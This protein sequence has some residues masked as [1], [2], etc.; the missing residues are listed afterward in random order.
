MSS[1]LL[2]PTDGSVRMRA[3]AR[4]TQHCGLALLTLAAVAASILAAPG[5]SGIL[6]ACLGILM[7]IV[8]VID[9][10]HFIIPNVLTAIG[11]ALGLIDA[12]VR[13]GWGG[14]TMAALRGAGLAVCLLAIR[15]AYRWLRGRQ[16]IGLGDVKLAGVAGVWLG[17]MLLPIAIEI[18]ALAA[19]TAYAVRWLLGGRAVQRTTRVPFGLFLAPTIWICWLV[20]TRFALT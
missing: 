6:G 20:E 3:G 10:R 2:L 9:A 19:L 18:A 8:A 15:A 16:G 17:W 11:F 1:P 5:L 12:G 13:G 14:A 4:M 7:L